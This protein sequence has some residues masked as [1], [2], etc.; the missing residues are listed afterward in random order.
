MVSCSPF[1]ANAVVKRLLPQCSSEIVL[2]KVGRRSSYRVQ[3]PLFNA[4]V[5]RPLLPIKL[6]P[7]SA[8]L[9]VLSP[10]PISLT[11]P[12][13]RSLMF[14]QASILNSLP[15]SRPPWRGQVSYYCTVRFPSV[16]DDSQIFPP[17]RLTDG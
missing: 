13:A 12:T 15:V 2:L 16:A 17:L 6:S 10:V 14:L 9:N 4:D 7:L 8:A 1:P 5:M 3:C 11:F